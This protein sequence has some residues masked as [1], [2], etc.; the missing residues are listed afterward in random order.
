[1]S[2]LSPPPPT[3]KARVAFMV[4]A[5]MRQELTE[6]LAYSEEQ[7][8]RLTPLQA[9]LVLHHDVPS[10]E[11]ESKLPDLEQEHLEMQ[12]A[13]NASAA[14]A[15]MQAQA[16]PP[17]QQQQQDEQQQQQQS[18]ESIK[19]VEDATELVVHQKDDKQNDKGDN[20][21]DSD[22]IGESEPDS[23]IKKIEAA[24][25]DDAYD[26]DATTTT[27][28][29]QLTNPT[30]SFTSASGMAMEKLLPLGI[31]TEKSGIVF[32]DS[33][34]DVDAANAS[35]EKI[36][37]ELIE[38]D[39]ANRESA[40][41]GLYRDVVEAQLA[42]ETRQLFERRRARDKDTPVTTSFVISRVLLYSSSS[43]T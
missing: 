25:A 15:A 4:T 19:H 21:E 8:K 17:P 22:D 41:V 43:S 20:Q 31:P 12:E 40:V 13:A 30:T 27:P 36:W 23:E 33:I 18:S 5:A 32:I 3:T 38:H 16:P 1:M 35:P 11:V 7:I 14:M 9:S 10:H 39:S 2:T 28:L 6:R 42:L 24:A 34:Q 26:D 37:F 29:P